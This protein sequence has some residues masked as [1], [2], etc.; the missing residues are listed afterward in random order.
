MKQKV[1]GSRFD[2]ASLIRVKPK[3]DFSAISL[4]LGGIKDYM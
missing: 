4:G 1:P 2:T 3:V